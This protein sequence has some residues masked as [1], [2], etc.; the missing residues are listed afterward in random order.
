M[1]SK[2]DYFGHPGR[3]QGEGPG[4]GRT[5][6]QGSLFASATEACWGRHARRRHTK[7]GVPVPLTSMS[8][9]H[10]ECHAGLAIAL[11]VKA[12]GLNTNKAC[13]FTC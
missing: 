6:A 2:P 4:P 13:L 3:R 5:L 8:S 10:G 1:D 7:L 11:S 9:M 12:L